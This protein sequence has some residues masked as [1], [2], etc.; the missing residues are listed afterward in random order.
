VTISIK[1]GSVAGKLSL[2]FWKIAL[3]NLPEGTFTHSPLTPD[4]ARDCIAHAQASKA[5]ACF[6]EDDL[7][8]PYCKDERDN[9]KALCRVLKK[10]YGITLALRDFMTTSDENGSYTTRPL[11]FAEVRGPD[12]LLVITCMYVLPDRKPRR[13]RALL[14]MD[15]DPST[16]KFHLFRSRDEVRPGR[17][18]GAPAIPPAAKT[19]PRAKR[20][21]SELAAD[22]IGSFGGPVDLSTNPKYMEGFGESNRRGKGKARRR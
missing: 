22:L 3:D 20:T 11:D 16:V 18:R 13:S 12:R 14:D 8:A 1:K 6:S 7:L 21:A 15:I 4:E 9:H 10:H 2:S 19:S 5:L 17:R